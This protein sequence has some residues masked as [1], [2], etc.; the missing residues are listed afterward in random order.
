MRLLGCRTLQRQ[1]QRTQPFTWGDVASALHAVNL[2]Q[3]TT[4]SMVFEPKSLR[5]RLASGTPPASS[6]PFVAL[7]LGE[8][9]R[10]KVA[11]EAK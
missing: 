5:L 9:F 2:G 1:W 11:V 10:H 6:G 3:D 8:L 4:Q 7:E